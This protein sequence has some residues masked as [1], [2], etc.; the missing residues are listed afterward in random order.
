MKKSKEDEN[1]AALIL[2]MIV[3]LA[4]YLAAWWGTKSGNGKER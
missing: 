3:T 4:G 2:Q 1:N